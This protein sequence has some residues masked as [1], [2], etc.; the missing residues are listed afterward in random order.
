MN[1]RNRL[2]MNGW[3]W[4]QN[5]IHINKAIHSSI[6][7]VIIINNTHVSI[8]LRRLSSHKVLLLSP[9][10]PLQGQ[11]S[12]RIE[13]CEGDRLKCLISRFCVGKLCRDIWRVKIQLQSIHK[14][15]NTFSVEQSTTKLDGVSIPYP[16]GY[17]MD[18]PSTTK[19]LA[20]FY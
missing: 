17:G 1:R 8:I 16:Q 14:L 4:Y 15:K 11:R 9:P 20:S 2:K 12:Q 19:P 18:T 6:Y 13:N 7:Y 3:Q 5:F 10:V